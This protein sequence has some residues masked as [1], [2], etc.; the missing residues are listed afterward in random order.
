MQNF[1]TLVLMNEWLLLKICIKFLSYARENRNTAIKYP[2][3]CSSSSGSGSP[4]ASASA[5]S[6]NKSR[7][8]SAF[9]NFVVPQIC[10]KYPIPRVNMEFFSDCMYKCDMCR[11]VL[12]CDCYARGAYL[13]VSPISYENLWLYLF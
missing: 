1:Q 2:I 9:T 8:P 3:K 7:M 13:A 5:S 12:A 4:S 6:D 11:N 10:C